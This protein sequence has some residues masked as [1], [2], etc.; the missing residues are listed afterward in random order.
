VALRQV[1]V[2]VRCL[3]EA[4][5]DQMPRT[6]N[7]VKTSLKGALRNLNNGAAITALYDDDGGL[8]GLDVTGQPSP[9]LQELIESLFG[10]E[11][12]EPN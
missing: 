1:I 11:E 6:L 3:V 7:F 9:L 12:S 4:E 5:E 10:E 8:L 2:E